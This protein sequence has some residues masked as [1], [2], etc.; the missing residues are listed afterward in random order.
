MMS[1]LRSIFLIPFLPLTLYQ[2]LKVISKTV[3]IQ[4]SKPTEKITNWQQHHSDTS[5][6]QWR[7][8]RWSAILLTSLV[9]KSEFGMIN[10]IAPVR[11]ASW[12]EGLWFCPSPGPCMAEVGAEGHETAALPW[13]RM[14]RR[15][16]PENTSPAPRT[17]EHRNRLALLA[18]IRPTNCLY[19]HSQIGYLI[20]LNLDLL[21]LVL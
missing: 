16:T 15:R 11:N 7:L 5:A 9:D 17:T 14:T 19:T 18:V 12:E 10:L 2:Y 4:K 21:H 20:L 3:R 6:I 8:V 13:K 1:G